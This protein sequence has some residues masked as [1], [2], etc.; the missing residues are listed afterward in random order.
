MTWYADIPAL[1]TRQIVRDVTIVAWTWVWVLV[2]RGLYRAIEAVRV[3]GDRTEAAGADLAGRMTGIADVIDGVPLVGDQLERPFVG[4]ADAARTL[5]E[6]GATGSDTVHTVAL[7][8]GF[9]V[10]VLPISLMLARVVPARLTWSREATAARRLSLDDD[11][12]VDLLAQ[13]AAVAGPISIVGPLAG[14]RRALAVL[15][16]RRL[17][18]DAGRTPSRGAT[19]ATVGDR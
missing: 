19:T 3:V 12:V 5:Q 1:R 18:I 11:E 16:L 13:R 2:G 4:A 10:A 9:L 7:W 17:G 6:A 8:A 15:E 14:D